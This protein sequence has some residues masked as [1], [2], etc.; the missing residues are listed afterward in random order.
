VA[1]GPFLVAVARLV[2]VVARRLT[3]LASHHWGIVVENIAYT[4]PLLAA[5]Q[6]SGSML[7][8]ILLFGV[9]IL[10]F[11]LLLIRPQQQAQQRERKNREA[12]LEALKKNDRVV[13]VGGIYGVVTNVHREADEV[14]IKVDEAANVKLRVTLA[15]VAQVKRKDE[16]SSDSSSK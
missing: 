10:L 16:S 5:Q 14:T 4:V 3:P 12:M 15:S 9:P 11:W 6:G 1:D 7:Q 8:P 2:E 13:T